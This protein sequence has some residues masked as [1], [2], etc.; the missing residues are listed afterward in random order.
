MKV[1]FTLNNKNITADFQPGETLFDY[2]RN[3]E[4]YSVKNGCDQG[5]CG[6]CTVLIEGKAMN[7]CLVLGCTL[8]NKKVE[9]LESMGTMSNLHPLQQRFLDHGAVQCGY[10]TPGMIVAAEALL[11]EHPDPSE[12]QI[13]DALAGVLCRCTGYVKPVKAVGTK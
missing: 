5:E 13:R 6:S 2:L 11:R 7:S 3:Q 1:A 12:E 8:E 9:T 4:I 10:C